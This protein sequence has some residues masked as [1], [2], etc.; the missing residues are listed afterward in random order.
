MPSI[1]LQAATF[2]TNHSSVQ[3][4]EII[5]PE[6]V[7]GYRTTPLTWSELKSIVLEEQNLAKLSRSVEQERDYQIYLRDLKKEWRSVYNHILV[8]KFG[9]EQQR[10]IEARAGES[11][12]TLQ[13]DDGAD[14]ENSKW[15]AYPPLSQVKTILKVLKR[16]DFPYFTDEGIEHWVLWKLVENIT[17]DEIEEAKQQLCQMLGDVVDLLHWVNPPHL[18]SLPEIDHAHILCLRQKQRK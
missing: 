17:D 5:L 16:N 8:S 1:Q 9:F 3:S 10:G 7:Y 15:Q 12:A 14:P 18:K 11:N 6:R 13:T 2:T 4:N